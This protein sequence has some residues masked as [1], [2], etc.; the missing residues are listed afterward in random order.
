LS[1]RLISSKSW[2]SDLVCTLR[3]PTLYAIERETVPEDVLA[4]EKDIYVQQALESG[5]PEN[6]V[7]KIVSGKMDKFLAEIC[8]LNRAMSKIL[9]FQRSGPV[10]R[11]RRQDG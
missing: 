1:P 10:D 8:L 6:I 3:R 4:R 5:K 11:L 2:L 9:I 7:E